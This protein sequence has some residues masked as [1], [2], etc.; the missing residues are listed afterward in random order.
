MDN[1]VR[2]RS[3]KMDNIIALDQNVEDI[4]PAKLSHFR[5]ISGRIEGTRHTDKQI[6]RKRSGHTDHSCAQ[7]S[8]GKHKNSLLLKFWTYS[9][10]LEF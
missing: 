2:L 6:Q 9:I 5:P 1:L 4:D 8:C 10:L 7:S 3:Y